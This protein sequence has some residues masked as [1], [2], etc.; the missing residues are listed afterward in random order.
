MMKFLIVKLPE[1]GA[2]ERRRKTLN[3]TGEIKLLLELKLKVEY[4]KFQ[5]EDW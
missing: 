1:V 4:F 2:T 5:E 3:L